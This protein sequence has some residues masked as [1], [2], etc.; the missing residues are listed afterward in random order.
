[1]T[2]YS[3]RVHP[4]SQSPSPLADWLP[5]L[6]PTFPTPL[7]LILLLPSVLTPQLNFNQ[8]PPGHMISPGGDMNIP[9]LVLW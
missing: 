1:M 6:I 3:H 5:S 2:E 4:A 9:L 8:F 7:N